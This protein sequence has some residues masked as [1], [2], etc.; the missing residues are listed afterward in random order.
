MHI[1]KLIVKNYRMLKNVEAKFNEHLNII[2]GDNECGKTTLIEAIN[3]AL[4]GQ[5]NGRNIKYELHPFLFN[6]TTVKEYIE[7]LKDGKTPSPPDI[8]IELYLDADDRLESLRGSN[9]EF[10]EDCPGIK[11]SIKFDDTYEKE[12]SEFIKS[13]EKIKSIPVDYYDVDWLSFRNSKITSRSIPIK[14]THIDAS[15][16][17]HNMGASRYVL[18]IIND[19]LEAAQRVEL[20]LAYRKM[21]DHFLD[22]NGVKAINAHLAT[23]KGIISNKNLSVSLDSTSR[24]NWESGIMPLL[25]E[26]PFPLVGAGEQNNVKI[27]L[28]MDAD[29]DTHVFLIE[30]PENHLSHHNLNYLIHSI[31]ENSS[32]KQ[33]IITT[34]SSFV[35]N[36][37]GIENVLLFTKNENIT[38]RDLSEDTYDYF[39]KLP[40]HDTL[41]LILAHRAI[42]VEGP[43]D[44]LIV[45]K[46]FK[47][48]HNC[49][50]LAKGVDV[51]SVKSLAFKRFLEIADLL[52]I[53]THVITDND[54]D[55]EALKNKYQDYLNHEKISIHYN[56]DENYPTLEPQLLKANDIATLNKALGKNLATDTELLAYMKNNKT[57]CALK[58]FNSE[59]DVIIPD[60]INDAIPQ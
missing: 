57:D 27:K 58:I 9:N 56:E 5:L 36:K 19:H 26:I 15:T 47:K 44:E 34:H 55:V 24:A 13:P 35:L 33:L 17:R 53:E 4:S 60:Y 2:V 49:S 59:E 42:L 50:P 10:R 31:S 11:L 32:N 39:M 22:D 3:L 41:R 14:P 23:K 20:A 21:K 8:L 18:D 48:I 7:D 45:Q 1:N 28:A 16:I 40:G 25:D 38:L 51:I 6:V 43:S 30:E 54:G 46:A 37:L 52:K 29:I 12:Y